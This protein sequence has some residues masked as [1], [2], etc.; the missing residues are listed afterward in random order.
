MNVYGGLH[1][2]F[3]LQSQTGRSIPDTGYTAINIT[4][5]LQ[6]FLRPD[7]QVQPGLTY[8]L[9][10]I[11]SPP[12]IA[13]NQSIQNVTHDLTGSPGHK[14]APNIFGENRIGNGGPCRTHRGRRRN[15]MCDGTEFSVTGKPKL[16][17]I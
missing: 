12:I 9:Q 5:T 10:S 2:R 4:I 6:Y 15:V 7:L 3:N 1:R 17:F 14:L 16:T 8:A 11:A 13:Q